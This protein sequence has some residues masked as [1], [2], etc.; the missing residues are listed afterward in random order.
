[1]AGECDRTREVPLLA[2]LVN[3]FLVVHLIECGPLEQ[4]VVDSTPLQIL[5]CNNTYNLSISF[6]Y[7][8]NYFGFYVNTVQ[9]ISRWVV[10][11]AEETST[12]SSSGSVL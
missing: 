7:S 12:N 6:I 10:G 9:A 4:E 2:W 3:M 8:F 11:R 5:P 1:M